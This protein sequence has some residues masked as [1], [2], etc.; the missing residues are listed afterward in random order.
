MT[1]DR[2]LTVTELNEIF[3]NHYAFSFNIL[4]V[5]INTKNV[6]KAENLMENGYNP[7]EIK[8]MLPYQNW[9]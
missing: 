8:R 4:E 3:G 5:T 2:I 6:K 9:V 1:T 7:E